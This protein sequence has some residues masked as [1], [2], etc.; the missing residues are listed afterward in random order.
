MKFSEPQFATSSDFGSYDLFR[1][2]RGKKVVDLCPNTLRAFAKAGLPVYRQGRVTF[3]SKSELS[4]FI[5]HRS[6]RVAIGVSKKA[7][8]KISP[9]ATPRSADERGATVCRETVSETDNINTP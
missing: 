6:T 8:P 5:R 7:V 9:A 3:I 4:A 1:I 2:S